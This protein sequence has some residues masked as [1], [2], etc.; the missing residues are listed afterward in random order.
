[1]NAILLAVGLALVAAGSA[2]AAPDKPAPVD[3]NSCQPQPDCRVDFLKSKPGRSQSGRGMMP[4][5]RTDQGS[6]SQ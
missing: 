1:M 2:D 4:A 5:P 6:G 3:E